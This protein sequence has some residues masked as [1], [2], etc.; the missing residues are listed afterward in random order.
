MLLRFF[1]F[2]LFFSIL[3][4]SAVFVSAQ[5]S[6]E[7]KSGQPIES[8]TPQSV[9]ENLAK[10]RIEQEK[11]E[12]DKLIKRGEEALKLSE[13]LENSYNKNK[14]LSN[15]DFERLETLEK[16]LKKIRNELGGDED[17]NDVKEA[18]PSNIGDAVKYLREN[19]INLVD[20]LQKTTRYS[21]SATAIQTSN[22]VLR[23]VKFMRFWKK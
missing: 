15:A 20:F 1:R 8:P 5:F 13:Q 2:S 16:L 19:T 21:I 9:Q 11:K 23:I 22:S 10:H 7:T 4:L 12:H 17:E 3:L 14:T 6:A 18:K